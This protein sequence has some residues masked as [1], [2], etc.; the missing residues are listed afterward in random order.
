MH[1]LVKTDHFTEISLLQRIYSF[2]SSKSKQKQHS[3]DF[4]TNPKHFLTEIKHK[5]AST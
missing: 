4:T 1:E 3:Q 5:L 2:L